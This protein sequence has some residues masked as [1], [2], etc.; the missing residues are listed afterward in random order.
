MPTK[1]A[2]RYPCALVTLVSKRLI[3]GAL[4]ELALTNDVQ[5]AIRNDL[6]NR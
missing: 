1:W 3:V 2:N 6:P 4:L 5:P